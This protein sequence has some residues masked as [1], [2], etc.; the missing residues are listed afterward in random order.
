MILRRRP[1]HRRPAHIDVLDGGVPVST[2]IDGLFEGI[3]VDDQQ[4][5]VADAMLALRRFMCGIAANRQEAAMHHGMQGLHTA[6]HHLGKARQ[7]SNVDNGQ[8]C[9]LQRPR[10][11]ACRNQFDALHRERPGQVNQTGLVRD[12]KQCAPDCS[13]HDGSPFLRL[14]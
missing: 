5:D 6:V 8:S 14:P 12:R 2:A 4:V 11:T 7:G 13:V 3:E 9:V 1:D 10:R